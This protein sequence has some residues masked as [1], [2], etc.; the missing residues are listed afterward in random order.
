VGETAE[1][2]GLAGL[3]KRKPAELSGGQ[4]QRVALGRAI[5]RRPAV[6]LM[7]EPL[8]NLD[9]KLRVQTRLELIKLHEE[10]QGTFI[11]VTHDQVEAMTMGSRIAIMHEGRLQQ[12][13]RPQDV[14]RRPANLF[15]AGFIGSPA[16]NLLDARVER[17]D[18]ELIVTCATGEF[19]LEPSQQ[20]ALRPHEGAAVVLGVRPEHLDLAGP[21]VEAAGVLR[22]TVDTIESLGHGGALSAVQRGFHEKL[23]SQC[24]YCTP[25]FIMASAGLLRRNPKPN[26]DEIRA[27]LGSNICRCTG[28]VKIIEAVQH[29]S[30]LLATGEARSP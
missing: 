5:V 18:D 30:A 26:E 22:A 23:G 25:G 17:R 4:R 27:A 10:L 15:V 3:L 29:A 8:S 28:Y 24:G 9:A 16:M 14:Y 11:Y 12:V 21:G 20:E 2:L 1:V 13:G 6:F 19:R 7:D